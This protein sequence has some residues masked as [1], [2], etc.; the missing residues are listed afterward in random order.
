MVEWEY[1][2]IE[3]KRQFGLGAFFGP[4]D[5]DR[6]IYK[7]LNSIGKEGWQL[8][9]IAPRAERLDAPGVTTCE[10]WIFKRPRKT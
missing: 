10:A 9:N 2:V 3:R 5:W 6:D 1:L 8:S 4:G 7:E